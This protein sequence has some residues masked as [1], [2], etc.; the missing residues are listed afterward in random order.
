MDEA[1][2]EGAL[3]PTKMNSFRSGHHTYARSTGVQLKSAANW[4]SHKHSHCHI[5]HCD[6]LLFF[7]TDQKNQSY[8]FFLNLYTKSVYNS[9]SIGLSVKDIL[10]FIFSFFITI[11][12]NALS[13]FRPFAMTPFD[14][15]NRALLPH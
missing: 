13:Q 12:F 10:I 9:G 15:E 1:T 7:E 5:L 4:D 14:N 8:P 2:D 6:I 3:V 11:D